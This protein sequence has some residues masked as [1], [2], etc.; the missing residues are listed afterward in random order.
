[1]LAE[2]SSPGVSDS[3]YGEE[4][5]ELLEDLDEEDLS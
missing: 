2:T 5:D 4:L 3:S 1:M